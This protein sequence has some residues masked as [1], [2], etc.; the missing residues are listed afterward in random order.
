MTSVRFVGLCVLKCWLSLLADSG[1]SSLLSPPFPLLTFHRWRSMA[2]LT[3]TSCNRPRED[4]VFTAKVKHSLL[5]SGTGGLVTALRDFRALCENGASA[6]GTMLLASGYTVRSSS[7]ASS[8]KRGGHQRNCGSGA[9][10]G[11]T[12]EEFAAYLTNHGVAVSSDELQYLCTAFDDDR[13]GHIT[14]PTFVRHLIGMSYR[15]LRVVRQAWSQLREGHEE[16]GERNTEA[17]ATSS[18]SIPRET[19]LHEHAQRGPMATTA[20]A[21]PQS[22]MDST[23]AR[24][25]CTTVTANAPSNDAF[26]RTFGSAGGAQSPSSSPHTRTTQNGRA[27]AEAAKNS[28]GDCVTEEEFIAFYAGISAQCGSDEAFERSVLRE[29]SADVPTKPRLGETQRDWGSEGDPLAIESPAYVKDALCPQLGV[30]SKSYN[31]SQLVREPAYVE[32]LPPLHRPDI[33]CST[34]QR[35]YQPFSALELTEADPLAT[36]RGQ[37]M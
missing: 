11:P 4:P 30:S 36:R 27:N 22:L 13:S 33:M 23:T 5:A 6:D 12:Y 35:T 37:A 32:P 1:L 21:A 20:A 29:W 15:R 18:H 19:L 8:T 28:T 16:E 17:N 34:V 2:S 7:S 31:Y 3:A 24:I 10:L 26:S 14:P 9:V 25:N